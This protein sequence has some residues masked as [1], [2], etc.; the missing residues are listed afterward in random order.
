MTATTHPG[1]GWLYVTE[2]G[3][4]L[5]V[6]PG[7]NILKGLQTLVRGYIERVTTHP[8]EVGFIADVWV[9]EDGIAKGYGTNLVASMMARQMIVGPAVITGEKDGETIPLPITHIKTLTDDGLYIDDREGA[10]WT[11]DEAVDHRALIFGK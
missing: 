1:E 2:L 6:R 5:L 3:D 8:D 4:V 7:D 11:I 10:A 9:N